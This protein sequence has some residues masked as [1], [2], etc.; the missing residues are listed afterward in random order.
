MLGPSIHM[1]KKIRVPPPWGQM[2]R[3]IRE[4]ASFC[5]FCHV[6]AHMHTTKKQLKVH[7]VLYFSIFEI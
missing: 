4:F 2:P 6:M 5:R 7:Y 1:R 3:L